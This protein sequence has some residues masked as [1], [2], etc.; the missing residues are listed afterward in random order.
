MFKKT[1]RM[2][3]LGTLLFVAGTVH[4]QEGVVPVRGADI[5]AAY[6]VLGLMLFFVVLALLIVFFVS[7]KAFPRT[8]FMAV[9][10][11]LVKRYV[12]I[13]VGILVVQ[14]IL[15]NLPSVITGIIQFSYGLDDDELISNSINLLAT[16]VIG[17]FLQAGLVSIALKTV[18]GGGAPRFADLFSQTR[19]FWRYIG[20]TI[21]Y[22]LMTVGGLLLLVFPGVI[23][24]IKFSLW[25]YFLV[26]KNV[27]VIESL[28]MSARA[29]AGHKPSLFVLYIYFAALNLLGLMAFFV[30]LFI[31]VPITLL[32]FA[33]V[34]RRLSGA[35]TA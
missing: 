7:P 5:G 4:A 13:F 16:A 33:W 12:W 3:S 17:V 8:A 30:G 28:K 22:G 11:P 25:P 35:D 26:D 34:Y 19:V 14:Q 15:V 18:A 21:L 2:A 24:F 31:T 23:W 9:S 20:G 1:F 27:G 32:T 6:A 10:W 29:T